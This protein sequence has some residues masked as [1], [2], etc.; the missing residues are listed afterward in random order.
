ML[1][2]LSTRFLVRIL[3]WV[4]SRLRARDFGTRV[5]DA[6]GTLTLVHLMCSGTRAV[7]DALGQCTNNLWSAVGISGDL[8]DVGPE[9]QC[10]G[11]QCAVRARAPLSRLRMNADKTQL[12]LTIVA[13][14][15]RCR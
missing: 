1:I 2:V 4:P 11:P 14:C 9:D 13:L 7:I 12:G 3:V 5:I 6:L 15:T 10:S 8:V